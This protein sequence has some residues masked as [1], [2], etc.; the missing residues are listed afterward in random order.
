M[1]G[2]SISSASAS[3][4][5]RPGCGINTDS[6]QLRAGE[7]FL[8]LRGEN[9]DGHHYLTAAAARGA[10]AAIVEATAVPEYPSLPLLPVADTHQAYQDLARAWRRQLGLPLVAVTGSAGKTTTR[11]LIKALLAPLG[12]IHASRENENNAVGVPR[13][14]LAADETTAAMVVEMAMRGPGE[15]AELS[16][17]AEP[18]L[19]VITNIGSA[20]IGRLGSREAIAAAKCEITTALASTGLVVIP[21]GDPLLEAGL[22]A[23]WHGA[24]HRVALSNDSLPSRLPPADQYGQLQGN[25][26]RFGGRYWR[27]PRPGT[28]QARNLMLALACAERLGVTPENRHLAQVRLPGGRARQLLL[29]AV[30]VWDETY[31]AAPE[32]VVATT[33]MVAE[34]QGRHFAVLGPMLELG[35]FALD[36]HQRIGEHVGRR[37]FDGLVVV[38]DGPLGDALVAGAGRALPVVQV[39]EPQAALSPVLAWLKPGDHLLLKASRGVALERLIPLLQAR[40]NPAEDG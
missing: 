18:D 37:G 29:G 15:I 12:A 17:C 30:T 6:R 22:A 31:N 5:Q 27:L 20:H 4:L 32:A 39:A 23:R 19:A 9:F 2:C 8:A 25:D 3:F 40:L 21:A 16:R 1:L 33:D 7:L 24:V 35:S 10:C 36:W 11:E 34:Q 28:H 14:I 13:T 38:D 26:L